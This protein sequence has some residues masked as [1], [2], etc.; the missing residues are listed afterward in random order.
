MP[1]N[2]STKS[3]DKNRKQQYRFF[4]NPYKDCAFTKCP[5]CDSKT[6]TRKFPLVI[7]IEPQQ[8]LLLNKQCKYCTSCDLIIIKK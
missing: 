5:R 3:S 2:S 7:Q 1:K 8:I 4:L 6:R